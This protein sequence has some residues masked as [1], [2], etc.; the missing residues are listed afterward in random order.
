MSG[1]FP[2]AY[3][4]VAS[5]LVGV[6]SARSVRLVYTDWV[7]AGT[8]SVLCSAQ[9]GAA[10]RQFLLVG[11]ASAGM[12]SAIAQAIC[13]NP[14]GSPITASTE[15]QRAN[16]ATGMVT[17]FTAVP[18]VADGAFCLAFAI[19]GLVCKNVLDVRLTNRR[20]EDNS[21][22]NPVTEY[23]NIAAATPIGGFAISQPGNYPSIVL[24]GSSNIL[25]QDGSTALAYGTHT[26][27]VS[28]DYGV[29]FGAIKMS[30]SE[31]AVVAHDLL[32]LEI[33][34]V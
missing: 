2:G 9:L 15:T 12:S 10:A 27:V 31:D 5:E 8:Q 21:A 23:A 26:I 11:N 32:V 4:G 25:L 24:D 3:A 33:N 29:I 1:S 30:I 17:Y 7:A 34:Y 22:V 28:P 6:E 16:L 18:A 20:Y 19:G 13:K 14:N